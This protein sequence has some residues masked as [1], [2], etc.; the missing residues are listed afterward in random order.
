M[1]A[2]YDKY[3]KNECFKVCGTLN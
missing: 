3:S 1:F 2:N